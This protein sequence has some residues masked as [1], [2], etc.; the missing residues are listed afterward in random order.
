M[1]RHGESEWNAAGRWQGWEDVCLTASGE[2]QALARARLLAVAGD[3]AAVVASDLVRAARTAEVVATHLGLSAPVLYPGLR[4]R[5]GGEWQGHTGAEIDEGWPGMRDAWRRG[6][7]HSP[8]GGESDASVL[9]RVDA[10]LASACA[11]VADGAA[12][13]AVT[14]G[15]VLRLVSARAGVSPNSLMPNLGGRW[16]T[17]DSDGLHAGGALPPLPEPL[18]ETPDTE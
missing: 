2:A 17:F 18:E 9:A 14:H 6:E 16:F 13:V 4:E 7:M 15:G 11:A 5:H 8:P 3:F 1:L 12:L 10:A